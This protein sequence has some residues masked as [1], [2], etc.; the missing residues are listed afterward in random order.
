MIQRQLG[1]ADRPEMETKDNLRS[2]Q[3]PVSQ[4]RK[5]GP[6]PGLL[7]L[8]AGISECRISEL[9]LVVGLISRFLGGHFT[10]LLRW[11]YIF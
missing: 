1:G 8:S 6:G 2:R 9:L 7:D 4:I 5:M 3:G 11:L 10:L